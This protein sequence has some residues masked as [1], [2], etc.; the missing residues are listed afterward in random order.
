[1]GYLIRMYAVFNLLGKSHFVSSSYFN[2]HP[3][4]TPTYQHTWSL[5]VNGCPVGGGEYM[6]ICRFTQSPSLLIR[7]FRSLARFCRRK[8]KKVC[9]SR[10]ADEKSFELDREL[11]ASLK[12]TLLPMLPAIIIHIRGQIEN[13][14]LQN[15]RS[16]GRKRL[17][18]GC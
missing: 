7:S 2:T 16:A 17:T 5:I 1:M 18:A 13:R 11:W 15:T 4:P 10:L 12:F 3:I 14:P 8:Q 6:I 9:R